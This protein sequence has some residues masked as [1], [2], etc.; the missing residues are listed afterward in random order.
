M[1]KNEYNL[2][3]YRAGDVF[4]DVTDLQKIS[5]NVIKLYLVSARRL[6]LH[7]LTNSS[8]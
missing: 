8:I 4:D 5:S 3:K 7:P 2:V 6:H 1:D